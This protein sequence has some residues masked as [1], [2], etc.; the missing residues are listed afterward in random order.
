MSILKLL[1]QQLGAQQ[2]PQRSQPQA[3]E[4]ELP[5]VVAAVLRPLTAAVRDEGEV[6]RQP[7]RDC[8]RC[9]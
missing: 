1:L 7:P 5:F 9:C 3:L 4:A 2:L 6:R 8:W